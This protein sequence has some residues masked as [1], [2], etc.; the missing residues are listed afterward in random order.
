MNSDSV[1]KLQH[2][3]LCDFISCITRGAN[4][5]KWNSLQFYKTLTNQRK[6]A[7]T[8]SVLQEKKLLYEN[9]KKSLINSLNVELEGAIY[10]PV[11]NCLTV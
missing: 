2:K 4:N 8:T 7:K 6:I 10:T 9:K 3:T 5:S 11:Y 1:S